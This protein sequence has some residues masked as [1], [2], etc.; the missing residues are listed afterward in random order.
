MVSEERWKKR[1]AG[2][3][4]GHSQAGTAKGTVCC[5]KDSAM[6]NVRIKSGEIVI[7]EKWKKLKV[8][9]AL[10][11]SQKRTAKDCQGYAV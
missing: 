6:A 9:G 4:F 8:E 7:E 3:A 5:V 2:G 1:N 10:G 11:K